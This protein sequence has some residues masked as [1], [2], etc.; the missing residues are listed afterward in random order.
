MH[1]IKLQLH[2]KMRTRVSAFEAVIKKARREPEGA[3]TWK[4]NFVSN[5][6]D[7]ELKE[8]KKKE[9]AFMFS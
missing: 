2:T 9:E 3:K 6:D 1:A 8:E 4:E 5:H 7:R